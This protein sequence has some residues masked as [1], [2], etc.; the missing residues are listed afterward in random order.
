MTCAIYFVPL[1]L[2]G[3]D[4]LV[5]DLLAYTSSLFESIAFDLD[6]LST[7]A[8]PETKDLKTIAKNHIMAIELSNRVKKLLL[9][10]TL[11][12]LIG[13]AFQICLAGFCILSAKNFG[14]TFT[15]IGY[16]GTVLT[17]SFLFCL[18]GHFLYE[19][20][21]ILNFNLDSI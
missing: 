19:S 1:E 14:M 8:K 13:A 5:L 16:L 18:G 9:L 12:Q 15:Y 20:V 3:V 4:N 2:S 6:E 11:S 10:T 17:Q 21:K 7:K